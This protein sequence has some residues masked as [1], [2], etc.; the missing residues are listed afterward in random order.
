MSDKRP[1]PPMSKSGVRRGLVEQEIFDQATRLFAQRGF[2]GTSFQDIADAVGLTRPALYY[3][4][5]SKDDLL[6]RL[7]AETTVS[8]ATE[9]AEL[10]QR[11]ERSATE[12]VRD[13]M[14]HLVRQQGEHGERF[15]LLLRSEADLPDSVS[16]SYDAN[17]RAVLRS[18][19]RVIEEGIALGEFRTVT[20]SIAAFGTLGIVNWVAWWYHPNSNL[21]L[22]AV[23]IELAEMA[24]R[25]LASEDGRLTSSN[26]LDVLRSLRLDIDRIEGMLTDPL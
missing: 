24:V 8:A 15:R 3:Y 26:P 6:A 21:D 16:D 22:E 17:R 25:S 10:A 11:E 13:I 20:P 1:E 23:S 18:I 12:R 7:V 19:T 5:K 4:V 9:V 2:S 14:R